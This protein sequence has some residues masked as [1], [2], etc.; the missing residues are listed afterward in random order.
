MVLKTENIYVWPRFKH[1]KICIYA[2]IHFSLS[3]IRMVTQIAPGKVSD[4]TDCLEINFIIHLPFFC[5]TSGFSLNNVNKLVGILGKS[6]APNYSLRRKSKNP[7][8]LH[9]TT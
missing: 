3:K 6:L 4:K 8:C 2:L 9:V 1:I 7:F 5:L